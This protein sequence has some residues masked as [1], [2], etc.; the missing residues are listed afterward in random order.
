VIACEPTLS[1]SYRRAVDFY[2][3][4][5]RIA[6]YACSGGLCYVVYGL[7]FTFSG[8]LVPLLNA[9]QLGDYIIASALETIETEE[10][11]AQFQDLIL[12]NV[13]GQG[14]GIEEVAQQVQQQLQQQ[15]VGSCVITKSPMKKLNDV[16]SNT[17]PPCGRCV[18]C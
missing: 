14:Q 6:R 18:C 12:E 3:A 10:L 7:T 5:T 9:S 11:L 4:L 16:G 15:Q 1:H 17:N 2:R 8:Q 13:Y